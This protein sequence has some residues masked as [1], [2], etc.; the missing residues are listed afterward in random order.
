[1]NAKTFQP[2]DAAT[3][4]PPAPPADHAADAS[5]AIDPPAADAAPPRRGRSPWLIILPAAA[6]LAA[7]AFVFVT[8]HKPKPPHAEIYA[9]ATTPVAVADA[10]VAAAKAKAAAKVAQ[11]A[12]ATAK[13]TGSTAPSA[14]TKT[15]AAAA[16]AAE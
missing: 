15:E 10:Q 6:L 2:T 12:A 11:Q 1:M 13:A 5:L 3:P 9:P 8:L 7:G 14:G 16:S 4:T